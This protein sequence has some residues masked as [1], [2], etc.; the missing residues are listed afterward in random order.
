[1]NVYKYSE[2]DLRVRSSDLYIYHMVN[3]TKRLLKKTRFRKNIK[4]N[5][6]VLLTVFLK[7]IYCRD[8][9]VFL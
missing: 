5:N 8:I 9:I 6:G 2:I 4:T 1:M 7:S 3:V